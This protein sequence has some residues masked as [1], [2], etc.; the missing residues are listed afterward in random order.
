MVEFDR[1][2]LRYLDVRT[3]VAAGFAHS[4]RADVLRLRG[5]L[6]G[7]EAAY[8]EA[9]SYGFEPQPGLAL[10]WLAQGRTTAAV[11]AVNR[12][13]AEPGLEIY[14]ARLL[15]AAVEILLAAGLVDQAADVAEELDR[16]AQMIDT[17]AVQ[18]MARYAAGSVL[19]ARAQ[20]NQ[21]LAPLR[22]AQRGF[23]DLQAAYEVARCRALTGQAY[24]QL[25][26]AE[27]ATVELA[28][29]GREFARLGARPAAEQV[30]QLLRTTA[31]AGLTAREVE[32][33]RLVAAGSSNASI[34]RILVLSEKTVA[35]H[36]SN[37]F[38]KIDVSSRTAAAAFAYEH[39]LV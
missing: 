30:A 35:R 24:Q 38:V 3:P 28:E 17:P 12:L 26:D 39:G 21:A 6:R 8:A 10:L 20:A 11:G 23:S 33:L 15:P 36:L 34:A 22:E 25:G 31:P 13:L 4:E 29:A 9:T 27:S 2:V 14:R 7:A 32:V 37:I 16:C 1:A 18:A 5:D 19:I